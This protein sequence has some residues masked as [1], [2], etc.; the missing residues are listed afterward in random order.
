MSE[1]PLQQATAEADKPPTTP[2]IY[3]ASLAD[4]NAGRL[5]GSWLDAARNPARS[6]SSEAA[7]AARAAEQTL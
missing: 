1:L 7:E 6:P 4:Y 5:H 2:R 3:V